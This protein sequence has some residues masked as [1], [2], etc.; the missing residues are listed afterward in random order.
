MTFE[1]FKLWNSILLVVK[2]FEL[3]RLVHFNTTTHLDA[4]VSQFGQS[5]SARW[6]TD[7][8][9]TLDTPLFKQIVI[10]LATADL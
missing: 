3:Y 5:T 6:G 7:T 4:V 8:T 2:V 1:W 9:V 10:N